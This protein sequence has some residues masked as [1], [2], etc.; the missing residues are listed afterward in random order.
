MTIGRMTEAFGQY[1]DKMRSLTQLQLAADAAQGVYEALSKQRYQIAV[2]EQMTLSDLQLVETAQAPAR[3]SFPRP[4]FQIAMG[5]LCGALVG[6]GSAL[7]LEY[8]DDS[9]KTPED[10]AAVSEARPLGVVPRFE[11]G[12]WIDGRPVTDPLAES[13]RTI[14]NELSQTGRDKPLVRIAVTSPMAGD[15]KSTSAW[16]LAV[17]Y[18][19]EGKR[20]LLVDGDLRRPSLHRHV[21]DDNAKGLTTVL[22]GEA[23]LAD[24]VKPTAVPGLSLLRERAPDERPRPTRR[25]PAPPPVAPRGRGDVR[26]RDCRHAAAPRRERRARDCARRRRARRGRR[27]R[28]DFATPACRARCA[29]RSRGDRPVGRRPQQGAARSPRVSAVPVRRDAASQAATRAAPHDLLLLLACGSSSDTVVSGLASENPIVREDMAR[30][31]ASFDD[32]RVVEALVRALDDPSGEVRRNAIDS[33]ATLRA[34]DAVPSLCDHVERDP[35]VAVRRA[36]ITAL[37]RLGDPRAV[38]VLVAHLEA[39]PDAPPLDAIWALG[40]IGDPGA[41][42][43]LS[44]L[45][46]SGDAYVSYNASRALERIKG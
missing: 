8:V 45:R 11:G 30:E 37:A 21:G 27:E 19:R 26:R 41:V 43:I 25:E 15:G 24:V 36:A 44:E 4:W 9:I 23:T 7:L 2:A 28:E 38:P 12:A 39:H 18:A 5:L 32:A 17:S 14:R 33:L 20:V 6:V 1:P 16:N 10:L 13:W 29:S 3:P 42:P 35:S 22:L 34:R 31:A 46:R 40:E